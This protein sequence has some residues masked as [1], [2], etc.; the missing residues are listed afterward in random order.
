MIA[1]MQPEHP[2]AAGAGIDELYRRNAASIH[3]F[4]AS[5]LGSDAADDLTQQTFLRALAAQD[6]IPVSAA[7]ARTWLIAIAR[8]LCI[9]THRR[10]VRLR[11]VLDRLGHSAAAPVNVEAVAEQREQLRIVERA[12]ASLRPRERELIGLRVA[13]SLSYREMAQIA[14]GTEQICKVATHRALVPLR[15]RLP[16]ALVEELES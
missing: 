7:E 3:R 6:R 9:D 5:Q 2:A 1:S 13:A 14:G 8:N 11:R 4:C 16:R 10:N 15:A 12:L